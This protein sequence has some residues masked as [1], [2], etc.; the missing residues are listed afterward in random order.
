MLWTYDFLEHMS[1]T[2]GRCTPKLQVGSFT[3]YFTITEHNDR[4]GGFLK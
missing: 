1:I 4:V 3:G 2:E